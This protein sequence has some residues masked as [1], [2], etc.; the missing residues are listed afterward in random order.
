M[1]FR[2]RAFAGVLATLVAA[3]TV[4]LTA[5]PS[6]AADPP[7]EG[8]ELPALMQPLPDGEDIAS[9]TTQFVLHTRAQ[10]SELSSATTY[11][12]VR[13]TDGQT[14]RVFQDPDARASQ[15]ELIGTS[16]VQLVDDDDIQRRVEV[17][18]AAT[19]TLQRTIDT[20][21]HKVLHA[22]LTWA[23]VNDVGADT[24]QNTVRF[25]RPDA[26]ATTVPENFSQP[27]HWLGGD[28]GTA[29]VSTTGADYAIDVAT[30]VRTELTF[31][32]EARL[33]A[34]TPT[35]L[36]AQ[37]AT[38]DGRSF[39][40][41]TRPGL[42]PGWSVDVRA[43]HHDR[44][45]LPYGEGLA[46]LYL[47]DDAP[48]S[49]YRTLRPVNLVTGDIMAPVANDVF[50]ALPLTDGQT[51]LVLADT[52]GGR[53]AIAT[54]IDDAVVPVTDLPDV[55]EQA[56]DLG[57]SGDRV[58]ASWAGRDGVW[59]IP[60]DG[61][62]GWS[63]AHT[64]PGF[65]TNDHDKKISHAGDVVMT[66]NRE[67]NR[68]TTRFRLMWPGGSRD[69]LGDAAY[70]GH[71]GKYVE[72]MD[73]RPVGGLVEISDVR[74]GAVVASYRATGYATSTAAGSGRSPTPPP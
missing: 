26:S 58:T 50:Q 51:A 9:A 61:S 74:T 8:V 60:A 30:G 56:L 16:L 29:Y 67:V 21:G 2:R 14:V 39:R 68:T 55:G 35:H 69:I 28:A 1:E 52:P 62:A 63:S 36:I 44:G 57:F 4:Q 13:V 23:M 42:Q 5:G 47:P 33:F 46:Q 53:I 48:S 24:G 45:F 49:R 32:D 19:G 22:D 38:S 73:Y 18:D 65:P 11:S 64:D 27:P 31:P 7:A 71:G 10:H 6:V 40:T 41:L 25:V 37:G 59:T 72:R 70:L 34:I 15:P 3:T 20:T 66:E 54:G 12:V 17:R 43:D